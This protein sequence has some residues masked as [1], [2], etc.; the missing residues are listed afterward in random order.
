MLNSYSKTKNEL[1]KLAP[2]SDSPAVAV[3]AKFINVMYGATFEK[4][5]VAI[6]SI[7]VFF[8]KYDDKS[9]IGGFNFD[10]IVGTINTNS[11]GKTIY[12]FS[13][14]NSE[15]KTTERY[16]CSSPGYDNN[17]TEALAPSDSL[18]Q[19]I[20]DE[21]A[22]LNDEV[23]QLN[24]MGSQSST[25]NYNA[26]LDSYNAHTANYEADKKQYDSKEQAYENY[27]KAHC[28]YIGN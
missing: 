7:T 22:Q 8:Q 21:S 24:K 26:L 25:N 4:D 10:R 19:K 17:Q 27:I 23:A 20:N 5:P 11:S 16:Q 2:K 14:H 18:R 28:T 15:T 3:E 6:Y 9:L 12:T 13:I 1:N